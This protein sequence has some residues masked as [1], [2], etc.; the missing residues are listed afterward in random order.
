MFVVP[1]FSRC[2]P[3]ELCG[4]DRAILGGRRPSITAAIRSAVARTAHTLDTD[5][6]GRAN[7]SRSRRRTEAPLSCAWRWWA[8]PP[9]AN[10][11]REGKRRADRLDQS[12]GYGEASR[13]L[14][15]GPKRSISRRGSDT[16]TRRR[17][18]RELVALAFQV[19]RN[20]A[21]PERSA[22]FALAATKSA[23]LQLPNTVCS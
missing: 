15:E 7:C 11:V 22:I 16:G 19:A 5:C 9:L 8:H 6:Q 1:T 3:R 17:A 23:K 21:D 14:R 12:G 20:I 10:A 18:G 4:E 2:P 13:R